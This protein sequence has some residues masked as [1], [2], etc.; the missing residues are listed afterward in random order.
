MCKLNRVVPLGLER[1]M[2]LMEHVVRYYIENVAANCRNKIGEL[3]KKLELHVEGDLYIIP[4][5]GSVDAEENF[6]KYLYF[7]IFLKICVVYQV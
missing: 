3:I 1:T 4:K 6:L 2:G 7:I 5:S